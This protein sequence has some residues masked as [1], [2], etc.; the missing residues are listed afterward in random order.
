MHSSCKGRLL[1]SFRFSLK[2]RERFAFIHF[3]G[4]YKNRLGASWICKKVIFTF[5]TLPKKHPSD[6]FIRQADKAIRAIKFPPTTD[7]GI[8]ANIIDMRI[9][10]N[11]LQQYLE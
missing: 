4:V 1:K 8:N 2:A 10:K 11:E 7:Y 5:N 6:A 9:K 3:Q